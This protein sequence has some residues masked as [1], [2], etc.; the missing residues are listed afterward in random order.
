MAP[1][2]AC[3]YFCICVCVGVC[4]CMCVRSC[5]CI[6]VCVRVCACVYV[7]RITSS[8][9]ADKKVQLLS[10]GCPGWRRKLKHQVN[11]WPEPTGYSQTHICMCVKH[12]IHISA[13][14]L[15]APYPNACSYIKHLQIRSALSM[16]Q[17][18]SEE[19]R[20]TNNVSQVLYE[21]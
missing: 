21:H 17:R 8:L 20:A 10:P 14:L 6:C 19:E 1:V 18:A 3:L 7:L 9:Q 5:I 12:E 13:A 11:S 16:M 2:C 4:L 15:P